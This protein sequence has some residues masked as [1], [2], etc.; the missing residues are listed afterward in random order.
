MNLKIYNIKNYNFKYKTN[1][2]SNYN[3]ISMQ[4]ENNNIEKKYENISKYYKTEGKREYYYSI[5]LEYLLFYI[6]SLSYNQ[7][8][9]KSIITYSSIEGDNYIDN[10]IR[11]NIPNHEII[12]LG[13]IQNLIQ[14]IYENN[15]YEFKNIEAKNDEKILLI[16]HIDDIEPINQINELDVIKKINPKYIILFATLMNDADEYDKVMQIMNL[17]NLVNSYSSYKTSVGENGLYIL[18]KTYEEDITIN[19]NMPVYEYDRNNDPICQDDILNQKY[20]LELFPNN[21]LSIEL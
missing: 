20:N 2:K 4:Q 17:Y 10:Y 12:N 1:H 9:N 15:N 14:N 5:P 6:K 19:F 21:Y 13:N 11:R 18:T 3:K 8:N 16:K 7:T